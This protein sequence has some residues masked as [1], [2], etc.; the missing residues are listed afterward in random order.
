[1]TILKKLYNLFSVKEISFLALILLLGWFYSQEKIFITS[2]LGRHI[3]N[4]K[5]F[6]E[7]G[8]VVKTNYYS[9]TEPERQVINHH[10]GSGVLFYLLRDHF[11][12][13]GARIFFVIISLITV[14]LLL[15]AAIRLSDF[16]TAYI[17]SV[18]SIP[19]LV[20]R[21]E[22]RPEIFSYF[23]L[24]LYLFLLLNV[25][26]RKLPFHFLWILGITQ[27]LWVNLHIFFFLG[28]F[29]VLT[30]L[31]D[32]YLNNNDI[33]EVKKYTLLILLLCLTSTINPY[34][35]KGALTPL[36]IFS[37]YEFEIAENSSLFFIRSRFPRITTFLHTEILLFIAF[38]GIILTA[39]VKKVR[40][41]IIPVII[42]TLF[43]LLTFRV[44]RTMPVFGF[45]FIPM[46]AYIFHLLLQCVKNRQVIHFSKYLLFVFANLVVFS[47][48]FM[49]GFYY[50]PLKVTSHDIRVDQYSANFFK[51]NN[52]KGPIFNN[53]D[54]GGYLIFNLFPDQRVF[55][56]N[57]PEAYSADFFTDTYIPMQRD[58]KAWNRIDAKYG[59][60]AI[61]FYRLDMA[62]WAQPFL[63]RRVRD[64]LWAPVFV[65]KYSIILLRRNKVN[66]YIISRYELPSAFFSSS[67]VTK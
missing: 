19:L 48:F 28:P 10:W 60:N 34:W 21:C 15:E 44:N 17:F 5:Q 51:E 27:I 39:L 42:M 67:K 31:I 56:D 45:F 6:I 1:M 52:I 25:R 33:R 66:E 9:Y 61:Y 43:G 36:T 63:M 38:S 65:D 29:L 18:L 46:G 24:A 32:S 54:I 49:N 11:D 12:F 2:D 59:F 16:K 22:I 7:H 35:I 37:E 53:Y 58:E 64:P 62:E 55:V 26:E 30:F 20:Y 50:S 41:A 13:K 40:Q 8:V 3:Q 23:F 4:G 57:R 14:C 47:A